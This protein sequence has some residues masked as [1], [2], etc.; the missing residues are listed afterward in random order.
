VGR[1]HGGRRRVEAAVRAP[2]GAGDSLTEAGSQRTE[3]GLE[4]CRVCRITV[5][6]GVIGGCNAN[7]GD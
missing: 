5:N 2:A 3:A 7:P 1:D 6:L 4:K